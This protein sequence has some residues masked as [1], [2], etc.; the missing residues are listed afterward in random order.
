MRPDLPLVYLVLTLLY[1]IIGHSGSTLLLSRLSLP[2]SSLTSG[3]PRV[4][5]LTFR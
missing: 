4:R 3:H 5:L 1:S 2:V